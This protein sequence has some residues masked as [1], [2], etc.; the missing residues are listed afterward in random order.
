MVE[1]SAVASSMKANPIQLPG[2]DLE[3]ILETAL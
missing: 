1:K 3:R 2:N